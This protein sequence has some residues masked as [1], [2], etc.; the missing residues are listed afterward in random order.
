MF[1]PLPPV[2]TLTVTSLPPHLSRSSP[3][4]LHSH[5]LAYL[6]PR[7]ALCLSRLPLCLLCLPLCLPRLPLCLLC[8]PPCILHSLLCLCLPVSCVCPSPVFAR[9]LCLPISCVCLSP[10][11]SFAFLP[12]LPL[13]PLSTLA[14]LEHSLFSLVVS[15]VHPYAYS[16]CL[17]ASRVH[18]CLVVKC[19]WPSTFLVHTMN[20]QSHRF[21]PGLFGSE[22]FLQLTVVYSCPYVCLS[23][24]CIH[25]LTLICWPSCLLYLTLPPVFTTLSSMLASGSYVCLYAFAISSLSTVL[26]SLSTMFVSASCVHLP[27]LV[28]YV[29]LSVFASLTFFVYRVF[30]LLLP[31]VYV[32]SCLVAIFTHCSTYSTCLLASYGCLAPPN[33][34]AACAHFL[35]R[36]FASPLPAFSSLL[37]IFFL[38]YFLVSCACLCIWTCTKAFTC[39]H[40]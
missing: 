18:L 33:L 25:S 19:V 20:L 23:V 1:A 15:H 21:W 40:A 13:C 26:A 6:S 27:S 9:L 36:S 22:V 31:S 2:S 10:P 12:C 4:L 17:S 14:S 39:S 7:L 29:S 35:L 24:S 3:C 32:P 8:S 34:Y 16:V 37:F 38:C 11:P 30:Y 28:S 5:V